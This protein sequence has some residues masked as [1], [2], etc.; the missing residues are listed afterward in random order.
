MISDKYEVTAPNGMENVTY[1]IYYLDGN[2]FDCKMT[3]SLR[4]VV[5]LIEPDAQVQERIA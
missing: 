4:S 5:L 2:A 1:K 3:M